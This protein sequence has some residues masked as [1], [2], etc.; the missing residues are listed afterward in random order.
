ME[1]D[2]MDDDDDLVEVEY[3]DPDVADRIAAR[4]FAYERVFRVVSQERDKVMRK[5][6]LM[7]LA[8]LRRSIKTGSTADLIAIQGGAEC[9]SSS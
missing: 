9:S 7:M 8:S 5:E 1:A 3:S 6:G 2:M 4:A